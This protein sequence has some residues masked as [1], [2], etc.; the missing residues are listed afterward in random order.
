MKTKKASM[1]VDTT[2]NQ[3]VLEALTDRDTQVVAMGR[4]PLWM[5]PISKLA[6]AAVIAVG[7]GLGASASES[8]FKTWHMQSVEQKPQSVH[9][10]ELPTSPFLEV[11]KMPDGSY[12]LE[13]A[14][15]A[16]HAV[17]IAPEEASDIIPRLEELSPVLMGVDDK[18]LEQR[19]ERQADNAAR[20]LAQT[21]PQYEA[22]LS[23][24]IQSGAHPDLPEDFRNRFKNPKWT[25]PSAKWLTAGASTTDVVE[26]GSMPDLQMSSAKEALEGAVE[27]TGLRALR[28][29]P[30]QWSSPE[31]LYNLARSLE[32]AN[33]DLMDATGLDGQ[34]LG[35]GGRLMLKMGSFVQRTD[36]DG[37]A[38]ATLDGE[39]F[40]H[41]NWA[42]LSHEWKH[43]LGFIVAQNAYARPNLNTM[44]HQDGVSVKNMEIV[45][46]YDD[47][48]KLIIENSP[49]WQKS[50][51]EYVGEDQINQVH[52]H[53]GIAA[54]SNLNAD[55][56]EYWMAP[57]ENMSYAFQAY[58]GSNSP[59]VLST[60]Y[61]G[62]EFHRMPLADEIE[63]Q[64]IVWAPFFQEIKKLDLTTPKQSVQ[65]MNISLA[66]FIHRIAF[67]KNLDESVQSA[68]S[69][70]KGY[71]GP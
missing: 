53:S 43:G 66:N 30:M 58:V 1:I 31:T 3:R 28:T 8:F 19:F 65:T 67:R 41:A 57:T 17:G 68:T 27:Y 69:S 10:V 71:K 50:I 45:Q 44:L 33:H 11:S 63:K 7:I 21:Y 47:A 37:I 59:V 26:A 48:Y 60:R 22:S 61:A 6:A 4:R 18:K 14:L 39:V 70:A 13:R 51:A 32:E 16:Y 15:A 46:A 12:S 25:E 36:A 24:I 40:I 35:L 55:R 9:W 64:K 23:A 34:V 54:T 52:V 29:L 5:R 2:L 56:R 38:V 49:N 42:N 62:K 20:E